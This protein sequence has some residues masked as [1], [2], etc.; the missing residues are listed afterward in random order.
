M[1]SSGTIR[2]RRLAE[3]STTMCGMPSASVRASQRAL[4][5]PGR[6]LGHPDDRGQP[7][8]PEAG[9]E[10]RHAHRGHRLPSRVPDGDADSR[11]FLDHVAFGEGVLPRSRLLHLAPDARRAHRLEPGELL[12]VRLEDLV[13]LDIRQRG[14]KGEA[15]RADAEG[16]PAPDLHREH[17]DGVAPAHAVRADGFGAASDDEEGRVA[18]SLGDLLQHGP[19]DASEEELLGGRPTKEGK[20]GTE[21]EL[22]RLARLL[23]QPLIAQRRQDARCGGLAQ[24]HG[25]RDVGEAQLGP[26]RRGERPE[27]PD[28]A[29]QALHVLQPTS[30]PRWPPLRDHLRVERA[31]WYLPLQ[32]RVNRLDGLPEEEVIRL[33]SDKTHVGRQDYVLARTKRMPGW[34]RLDLVDVQGR[35]GDAILSQR[36]EQR[37][38]VHQRAPCAVDEVG[39]A[40]HRREL[41]RPDDAA[42]PLGEA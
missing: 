18:R 35:P 7:T 38:L 24:L 9:R 8:V 14:E 41:I 10:R 29:F 17:L 42:G 19:G 20:L 28:A 16:A 33:P 1:R 2:P 6:D 13:D 37:L 26:A 21:V 31:R 36:G 27:D 23:D 15:A 5:F 30:S 40:L 22:L 4:D 12:R 11:D 3:Y 39:T 32:I 34:E 25:A